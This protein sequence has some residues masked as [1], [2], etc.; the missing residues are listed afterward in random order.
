MNTINRR[1]ALKGITLGAGALALS[2]FLKHLK[3]AEAQQLP[4]RFVFVVKSSGL[5]GDYL[6]P[7]GLKH[8]GDALV[9]EPLKGKRLSDCMKSLEPFKDKLTIIQGLSGRMTL[10]GHSA[11][12]GALGGY[13]A[14]P[15]TPTLFATIDGHLSLL[16]PSVF[17]H[18]GLKMG[19]GSQGT[20][21]PAISAAGKACRVPTTPPERAAASRTTTV[22]PAWTRAWA[23]AM[24]LIPAPITRTSVIVQRVLEK[25][26][27]PVSPRSLRA[28]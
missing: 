2:P 5:Q 23:Q 18:I 4:K 3:A 9:D 12:Y 10:S 25:V 24:P 8:R 21:Y 11:F 16:F 27:L 22:T 6:N 20:T 26:P 19:T 7:E 13:K 1:T 15:H 28:A 14:P 17:N